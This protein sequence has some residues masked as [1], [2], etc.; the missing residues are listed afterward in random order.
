VIDRYRKKEDV[1][2]VTQSLL[3]SFW[4]LL[5]EQKQNWIGYLILVIATLGAACRSSLYLSAIRQPINAN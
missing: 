3:G 5:A 2:P 4:S 1:K